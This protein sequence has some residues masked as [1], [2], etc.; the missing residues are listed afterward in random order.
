MLDRLRFYVE[1]NWNITQEL[2]DVIDNNQI[3]YNFNQSF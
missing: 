2:L 3:H 1:N